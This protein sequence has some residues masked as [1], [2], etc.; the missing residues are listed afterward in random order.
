M[1]S[2]V[3]ACSVSQVKTKGCREKERAGIY[4]RKFCSD[5][6]S[7]AAAGWLSPSIPPSLPPWCV[8]RKP[9]CCW[10]VF[11]LRQ[12]EGGK[13]VS[14]AVMALLR[15]VARRTPQCQTDTAVPKCWLAHPSTRAPSAAVLCRQLRRGRGDMIANRSLPSRLGSAPT[16]WSRPRSHAVSPLEDPTCKQTGHGVIV[17]AGQNPPMDSRSHNE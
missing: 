11:Q 4:D 9:T 12:E 15:N 16:R 13:C 17:S 8:C 6:D 1:D 3:S 5:W 7:S 2:R 10:Q 14:E